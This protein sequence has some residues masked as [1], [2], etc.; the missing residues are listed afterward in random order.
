MLE[1]DAVLPLR[2]PA[3]K[4]W[5]WSPRIRAGWAAGTREKVRDAYPG[6]RDYKRRVG[7]W[8]TRGTPCRRHWLDTGFS[9]R[10]DRSPQRRESTGPHRGGR[11]GSALQS[12]QWPL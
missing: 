1:L 12:G 9:L 10:N 7:V 5:G 4:P 2:S 3:G 11:A 6:L 8:G